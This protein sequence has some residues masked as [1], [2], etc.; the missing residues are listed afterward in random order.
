MEISAK[1][2]MA[3]RQKTGVS[4]MMC[5]EALVEAG[6]DSEK[7]VDI[8]KTKGE[9]KAVKKSNRDT[10]E[11][12]VAV[13]SDEGKS[14]MVSVKCETDFVARND[15][16]VALVDSIAAKTLANG[17]GIREDAEKMVQDA[18]STMGENL[19]LGDLRMVEGDVIGSYVHSN[20]KIGVVIVL[21]GGDTEKARDVAMH[22][23]AMAPSHVSPDEVSDDDVAKEKAIWTEQLKEEGKPDEIVEKI[24]VGKEKKFREECA[25]LTQTF[26]KDSSMTVGEYLGDAKIAEYVRLAV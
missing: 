13:M 4:M 21:D 16:F 24:M 12:R 17:E 2:V 11:G 3:L 7:A 22:A 6:G 23:A 25:L 14:S 20:G 10:G 18:V 9:A 8:L 19:Q 5:K 1:D 15:D 26:V